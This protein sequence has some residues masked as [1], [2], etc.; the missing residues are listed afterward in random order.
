DL[1]APK[2]DIKSVTPTTHP[3]PVNS[4]PIINAVTVVIGAAAAAGII[5]AYFHGFDIITTFLKK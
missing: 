2:S 5:Y 4:T 1:P 3:K